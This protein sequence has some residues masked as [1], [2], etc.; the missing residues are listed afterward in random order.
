[1]AN[2]RPYVRGFTHVFHY[3]RCFIYTR[4]TGR[5]VFA[6]A[7]RLG[8]PNF[9][10][11]IP[12]AFVNVLLKEDVWLRLPPGVSINRDGKQHKIVKLLRA[13][14]GLRQSP[15]AFNKELVNFLLKVCRTCSLHKHL[16]TPVCFTISI[17]RLKHPC[18]LRLKSMT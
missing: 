14:Y 17:R 12:Q 3:V 2:H 16:L 6:I 9:Y 11:D 5:A 18:S 7:V 10:A 1:M 4:N 8:L 13:L 15:R